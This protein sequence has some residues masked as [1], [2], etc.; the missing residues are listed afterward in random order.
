VD[1]NLIHND[2]EHRAA[3]AEIERLW[4]APEGSEEAEKLELLATIVEHYED[5]RWP[6]GN[7]GWDAVDVLQYAIDEMGHTRKELADLFGSP[8][9]ASEIMNRRGRTLTVEMIRRIHI[10]WKIPL[11]LLVREVREPVSA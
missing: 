5:K 8:P 1:I 6:T 3:L 11:E 7:L 10:A 9:H 2:E 4:D